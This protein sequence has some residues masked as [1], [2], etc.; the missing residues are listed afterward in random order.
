MV[1]VIAISIIVALVVLEYL[2]WRIRNRR[3]I[4]ISKSYKYP[5]GKYC[6]PIVNHGFCL[7]GKSKD[8][9]PAL[10]EC[11]DP[12]GV[13]IN[14]WIGRQLFFLISRP[15]DMKKVLYEAS[16]KYDYVYRFLRSFGGDNLMTLNGKTFMRHKRLILPTLTINLLN[17]FEDNFKRGAKFI[18][19]EFESYAGVQEFDNAIEIIYLGYLRIV[20]ESFMGVE[21]DENVHEIA[22]LSL[23]KE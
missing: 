3:L 22:V 14:G 12:T 16:D 17:G 13:P 5:A 1:V 6:L 20:I 15:E 21:Y 4:K 10:N 7:I 2:N 18:A 23:I 11:I 19:D 9:I 8:L